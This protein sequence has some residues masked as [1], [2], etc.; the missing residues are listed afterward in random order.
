MSVKTWIACAVLIGL[1]V[2][3]PVLAWDG[4]VS[5][6]I[7]NYSAV[8]GEPGNAEFRVMLTGGPLLCTGGA[9]W[10]YINTSDSNYSTAVVAI[11]AKAQGASVV[12][13]TIKDTQSYCHIGYVI[14][15]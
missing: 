7:L 4:N 14:I 12:L 11:M 10:A 8:I 2:L 3:T 15:N 6:T 1:D 9:N 13:Y 5:G